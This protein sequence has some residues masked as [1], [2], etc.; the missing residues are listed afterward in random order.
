MKKITL[1]LTALLI[2]AMSFATE[3]LQATMDFSTN[4]WGF[5]TKSTKT[6][7]T[8]TNGT[9]TIAVSEV[10][11]GGHKFDTSYKCFIVGK[12]KN[13]TGETDTMYAAV[14]LPP[15]E[16]KTT[17]IIIYGN[18]NGSGNVTQN[19]YV[20]DQAVS[21]ATTSG[22]VDHTYEIAADYQAAGTIYRIQVGNNFNSHI[23]K[24]EIFGQAE[25]A[26]GTPT[27]NV[28]ATVND[29]T[30]G[31]VIGAGAYPE[32]A[33]MELTAE[34]NMGYEFV[35]WNDETTTN[36]RRITVTADMDI[37]A[38]FQALPAKTIA[39]VNALDDNTTFALNE[40]VV[41]YVNG[42][43]TYIK[44]ATGYAVICSDEAYGLNAGDVVAANKFIGTKVT[45]SGA[46][47]YQPAVE[48]TAL[49]ATAGT[50]PE[51]EAITA[52]QAA[53]VYKYVKLNQV[54]VQG[55]PGTYMGK[56]GTSNISLNTEWISP[57]TT[58]TNNGIYEV[59]GVVT[60]YASNPL[61]GDQYHVNILDATKLSKTIAASANDNEM[62]KVKGA[63]E[64]LPGTEITL[65]A[66]AKEGYEFVN[67]TKG[68]E[69][70]STVEAYTF[71]VS[72][73]AEFVANFQEEV[74]AIEVNVTGAT[75]TASGQNIDINAQWNEQS[76]L[77]MLWQGGATQG[78]GTYAAEDYGP[79]MLGGGIKEL[80][81]TTEGVYEDNGDGTFTFTCSATDGTTQYNITVTGNN[82]TQGG[83]DEV[84]PII[85]DAITN[86]TFSDDEMAFA[87]GPSENYGIELY[88]VLGQDDGMGTFTLT[89][90]S[91]IGVMGAPATFI[92]GYITNID[93]E[94]LSANAVIVAKL[95]DGTTYEFHIAMSSTP[96]EAIVI[97]VNN[98]TLELDSTFLFNNPISGDVYDYNLT[99]TGYW[100]DEE[101]TTYLVKVE[102]PIYDPTATE[103]FER[104]ANIKVGDFDA[105]DAPFIGMVED[106]I[107]VTNA[108]GVVTAAGVVSENGLAFDITISGTLPQGPT[109]G[110]DNINPTVA[111]A[112][113]IK[114]GQLIIR[115]NGVEFNAQGAVVK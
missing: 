62:G 3:W 1:F 27:Y 100:T 94:T 88:L 26:P 92:S 9:Y 113:M 31:K 59:V 109:T 101:N 96:A 7:A 46:V 15:F 43:N 20:G 107:T 91:V 63:G 10:C 56:M 104:M 72:A 90:E 71:T 13:P 75:A 102:I 60:G 30:M 25:V 58:Y 17:K 74:K 110:V 77:I 55:N 53:D 64:Y 114:N 111:P 68:E 89:S 47:Q 2:S 108:N 11:N 14:T 66:E 35:K 42:N 106:V 79:I 49:A 69:V 12:S 98:A 99:M 112:K 85:D 57:L 86:L 105:D 51:P 38:T 33:I 24:I 115:S 36:P 54:T 65:T 70:V 78:F 93:L 23:T 41:T 28:T 32:G 95:P 80:T 67:W 52:L 22:K 103:P 16:F 8:Y 81:P 21:T 83:G 50:A 76:M 29:E 97:T 40:F 37:T 45:K 84:Y 82:P 18:A 4:D 5:P 48:A 19:I 87:G 44:D 73:D 39:E 61:S 6:A 34:P